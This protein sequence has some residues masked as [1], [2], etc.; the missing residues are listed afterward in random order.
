MTGP[1]RLCRLT[2]GPRGRRDRNR[3]DQPV[4][5]L[6]VV[7]SL[8]AWLW[9]PQVKRRSSW[10]RDI[11]Y[12][13]G[14]AGPVLAVVAI[15]AQL[16]LG[17]G[18][19]APLYLVS[20]MTLGFIPWMTVLVLLAWAAIACQL[21]AL[22]AGRY[23]AVPPRT[24]TPGFRR[25]AWSRR[26]TTGEVADR[27]PRGEHVRATRDVDDRVGGSRLHDHVRLLPGEGVEDRAGVAPGDPRAGK[28]VPLGPRR[29]R[30]GKRPRPKRRR[31]LGV[32]LESTQRRSHEEQRPDEG[33]EWV[34]RQPEHERRVANAERERLTRPHRNSQKTSSTPRRASTRRTRSCGPDRDA[35]GGDDH[36]RL[37]RSRKSLL[38]SCF[39]VLR[40]SE[41]LDDGARLLEHAREHEPVRL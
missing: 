24:P 12:G 39:R 38:Q 32:P 8:Y 21:G 20:L 37:E 25:G 2:R 35:T 29:H 33:R 36:I 17:L 27:R 31:R 30:P 13:V 26:A 11:L 6:F 18:L 3:A 16:G 28:V 15:G 5:L 19:D 1:R 41:S 10:A 40:R 23:R 7:P 22:A 9:L 34:P 14:L 4:R